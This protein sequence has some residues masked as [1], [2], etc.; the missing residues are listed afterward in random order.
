[1]RRLM[2]CG[3]AMAAVLVLAAPAD[4]ANTL[5]WASQGDALTFDPHAQ[6]EGP[7]N[8]ANQQVYEPLIN[9]NEKLEMVPGLAVA[10]EPI[11]PTVWEFKLRE[12]VKY[13]DGADFTSED[14][15]FSFNRA[16]AETS[17]FKEYI[18]AVTEVKAIDD[19]TVQIVT[20][21]PHP[22]LPNQITEIMMMDKG[23]ADANGVA[24]PQN[25]EQGE[26]TFA[27]RNANGTGPFTLE[28]REPDVRTVMKKNE[29]WWGLADSGHNIDE[30]IYTPISNP[31]TRVA[32]LLSGEVDFVL[33]PPLQD[34]ERIKNTPGLAVQQ[35]AQIR[36]IFL[37]MDTASDSLHFTEGPNPFKDPKVRQAMY[38]AIDIDAI[39]QKVMRGLSVPAGIITPP[40]V[41]GY[42]EELNGRL[43][44]DPDAA[45]ALLVEAGYADGFT[46]QLNC[47]ND[48]Y[49]NDEAICQAVVGMLGKI[50]I[51]VDLL[52]ETKSIHFQKLPKKELDFYMLG[53]GV[54][55]LDSHYV[56]NFLAATEGSWNATGF[57]DPRMDELTKA[58][59]TTV[60][61]AER[62]A[63]IA[64]A[65][66]ILKA[67]NAYLPLHHQVIAWAMSDK[68]DLPIE[69]QD[70][71]Q[72]SWAKFN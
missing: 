60:D 42:T 58:M 5:R 22:L 64:E 7:T 25:Y 51:T 66:D 10:W 52:A 70:S 24:E 62:D 57:S 38:Q 14:V 26:E 19:Y 12:G 45:K 72:F 54:P 41:N 63:M 30:I 4:A 61:L 23:W 13:H 27:V 9:R 21:G 18:T 71:P 33:D 69:A 17:N 28:L 8:T 36:T 31:A 40:G 11:E 56:F 43:P 39:Q 37:G 46:T 65:W 49:N 6:N 3:T 53:W 68:L 15:V 1:M 2:L 55:T 32:A 47:P 35:T 29:G 67:S 20:E 16:Q 44:Y 34:L 59:E 50:G 48:R